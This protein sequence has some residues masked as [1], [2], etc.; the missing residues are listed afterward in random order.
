ME[1]LFL[2]QEMND[3]KENIPPSFTSSSNRMITDPSNA[4]FHRKCSKCR[5]INTRIPLQDI[6]HLFNSSTARS[7]SLLLRS[8]S[9]CS[10]LH[11]AVDVPKLRKRKA[12]HVVVADHLKHSSSSKSLRMNFR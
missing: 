3:N 5:G 1:G 6:T 10:S 4:R 11:N 2:K 7:S 12:L 9:M 8:N